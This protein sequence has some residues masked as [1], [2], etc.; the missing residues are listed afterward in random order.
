MYETW[1]DTNLALTRGNDTRTIWSYQS[2]LALCL[3]HV[4]DSDHIMLRDTLRDANLELQ[5]V[6][7]PAWAVAYH[8]RHL[9]VDRLFDALGCKRRRNEDH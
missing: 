5:R 2:G 1:H 8:K 7:H 3:E 6:Y 9:R 4:R